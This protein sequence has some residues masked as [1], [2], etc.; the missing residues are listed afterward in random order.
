MAEE[1]AMIGSGRSNGAGFES[2]PS[3]GSKLRRNFI[4]SEDH[5]HGE[6]SSKG[7]KFR[8][9]GFPRYQE[10]QEGCMKREV[11]RV[12][13]QKFTKNGNQHPAKQKNNQQL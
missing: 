7:S 2:C 11:E 3:R 4:F 13:K 5:C 6:E 12:A 1:V 8:G 10:K 9:L